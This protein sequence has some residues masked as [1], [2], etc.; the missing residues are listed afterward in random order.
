MYQSRDIF[1]VYI[2]QKKLIIFKIKYLRNYYIFIL[3]FKI[4]PCLCISRS[5]SPWGSIWPC[6]LQLLS[7]IQILW[8]RLKKKL[9]QRIWNTRRLNENL[10]N[11]VMVGGE[12][13]LVGDEGSIGV[14]DDGGEGTIVVHEHHNLLPSG[15][16][17]Y[18]IKHAQC[19]WMSKL[20]DC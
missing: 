8:G 2:W 15:C 5:L 4:V 1:Y 9:K 13:N 14:F 10:F 11:E 16:P 6:L 7:S 18:L 3:D 17:H 19:W 12:R 20:R